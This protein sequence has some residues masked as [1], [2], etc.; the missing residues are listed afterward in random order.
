MYVFASR[1]GRSVRNSCVYVCVC[2]FVSLSSSVRN[3]E[4]DNDVQDQGERN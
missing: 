3:G 4:V 1:D 2:V